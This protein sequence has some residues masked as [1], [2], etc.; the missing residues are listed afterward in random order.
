VSVTP[1]EELVRLLEALKHEGT[2]VV[3][4]ICRTATPDPW[5]LYPGEYGV[6]D[7]TTSSQFYFHAHGHETH[8]VGHFHTV[9]LFSDHTVHLVGIS[10][11]TNGWPQALFTLNLWAIGDAEATAAEL[12]RYVRRF[13][14]DPGRGAPRV[15]RFVNLMF[16]AFEAEI[17]RLQD[18]KI[19][20][21]TAYRRARPGAEP[22]EDRGLE[23][24]SCV[25]LDNELTARRRATFVRP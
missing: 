22:L 17:E 21:L 8:E 15:V 5:R 19:A 20:T 25:E 9:R 16:R 4:L 11:A 18:E 24:L 14:I 23:V 2:S 3:E 7:R 12:K 6:F 1:R 10:M 13:R